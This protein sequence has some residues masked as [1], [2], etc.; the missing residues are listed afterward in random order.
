MNSSNRQLFGKYQIQKPLGQGGMAQVYLAYDSD[1]ER[2]VAIKVMLGHLANNPKLTARFK[3]EA[4]AVARLRHPN[5]LQIY[6]FGMQEQTQYMVMEYINGPTLQTELERR[7]AEGRPYTPVEAAPIIA[8]LAAAVDYAHQQGMLHRDIKPA[9]IM[10]NQQGQV[11]LTDFGLAWMRDTGRLTSTGHIM[12]TPAYMSPEQATGKRVDRHT[13]IYALGVALYEMLT[14]QA[15]FDAPTPVAILLKVVQE[16]PPLPSR[17]NRKISP[18][19][20]QVILTA[21]EKSPADRFQSAE[22]MAH[23]L[24]RA[25]EQ[26]YAGSTVRQAGPRS[27]PGLPR[28]GPAAAAPSSAAPRAGSRPVPVTNR[29]LAPYRLIIAFFALALLVVGGWF[30]LVSAPL[31]PGLA[32][33]QKPAAAVT[34]GAARVEKCFPHNMAPDIY[35]IFCVKQVAV[36]AD[37]ALKVDVS[38]EGQYRDKTFQL[39]KSSDANNPNMYLVDNLG[40]RY[41]HTQAG[42]AAAEDIVLAHGQTAAGWFIF[43]PPQPGATTFIFKDDDL[44]HNIDGITPVLNN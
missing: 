12:G 13:D 15:P 17:F 1:L 37:G 7:Y 25:I 23:A 22:A 19:I 33:A 29:G 8:P 34:L 43:P 6:E 20:E 11:I 40:N 16:P 14:C 31:P 42:G 5:I 9:N 3:R 36:Q 10:F 27:L 26:P 38:W 39:Q 30:L 32:P 28:P 21:L 2:H 41:N 18:A 4:A 24:C 35:M 44:G